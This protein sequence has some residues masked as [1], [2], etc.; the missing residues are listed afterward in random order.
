MI[1]YCIKRGKMITQSLDE[2][3]EDVG[4]GYP[5]INSLL[6]RR[7]VPSLSRVEIDMS[8]GESWDTSEGFE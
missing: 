2:S 3:I 1:L 5:D 7:F 4:D 8:D 6:S